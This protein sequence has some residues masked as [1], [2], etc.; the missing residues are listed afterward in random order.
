MPCYHPV[1][2]WKGEK[3]AS[4]KRKLQFSPT[5]AV[6][7]PLEIPCGQCIGCRLR[8][9][10]DWATRCVHEAQFHDEKCFLTLTYSPESLPADG[11]VDVAV[12][13][14]FIK[15]LRR[16]LDPLRVRYFACGEYGG[17]T[18][19]PHYHMLLFGYEFLGD[20]RLY[21]TTPHGYTYTSEQLDTLW[22]LGQ[23]VIGSLTS[24]SAGYVARYS[25]K[26]VTGDLAKRHYE[27]VDPVTGEITSVAPEFVVMSRGGK[28]ER[29]IG[30]RFFNTF[31]GDLREDFAMV[32]NPDGA[33]KV[34]IPK[35]YDKLFHEAELERRKAERKKRALKHRANQTPERLAVREEVKHAQL[36]A[37]KRGNPE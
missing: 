24:Q 2:A 4:G 3:T 5:G 26:K 35:Y 25:L 20:R 22:G 16:A 11:S 14:R 9:A 15:R 8:R 18:L 7:L 28:S 21:K 30:Y 1:Q 33:N 13:Q 29:G 31:C 19:R 23:C 10:Q 17:R 12:L 36:R 34:P 37:L 6:G 32:M 27:R